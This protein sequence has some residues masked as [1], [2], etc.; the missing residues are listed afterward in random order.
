MRPKQK[1]IKDKHIQLRV[2]AEQHQKISNYAKSKG[3][4]ISEIILDE[5]KKQ[6]KDL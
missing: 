6:I 3:R 1:T 5:L 4:N 2:T